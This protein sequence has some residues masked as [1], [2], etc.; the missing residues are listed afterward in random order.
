M[1]ALEQID[2]YCEV[3]AKRVFACALDW[4]GWCRSGR[5]EESALQALLDSAPRYAAILKNARIAFHAARDVKAF[6]VVERLE[7][8]TST[9]FGVPEASPAHDEAAPSAADLKHWLKLLESYWRAFDAAIVASQGKTLAKGPRG[10]GRDLDKIAEHVRD[11]EYGYTRRLGWK[12]EQ[13]AGDDLLASLSHAHDQVR[14]ALAAAVHD[15]LPEHGPRGGKIW[16]PGYFVRRTG[17]HVL[18]HV[19]E[20]EDRAM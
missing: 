16:R 1:P 5:D 6:K 14:Q 11:A 2:V 12:S 4:H 15:G 17:W 10:G 7:G 8:G 18:D 20:I 13:Y 9:D 3:G 19:W